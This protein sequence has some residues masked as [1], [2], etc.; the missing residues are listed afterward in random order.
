MDKICPSK[1]VRH[2]NLI[3]L[4]CYNRVLICNRTILEKNIGQK[5][6]SK[7]EKVSGVSISIPT[8]TG[9]EMREIFLFFSAAD[10]REL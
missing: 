5:I 6:S 7:L 10:P 3:M 1:V 8:E 4:P 9:R 2:D